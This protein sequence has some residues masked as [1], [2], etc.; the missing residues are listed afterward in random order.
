MAQDCSFWLLGSSEP[1]PLTVIAAA[2]DGP[3]VQETAPSR[4]PGLPIQFFNVQ[5]GVFGPTLNPA[6]L[7][8]FRRDLISALRK[9]SVSNFEAY[10]ASIRQPRSTETIEDY[11]VIKVQDCITL[12]S[13]T[14]PSAGPRLSVLR[15][16]TDAVVAS[17]DLRAA[18]EACDIPGLVFWQPMLV[19]DGGSDDDD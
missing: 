16:A 9:L 6:N 11:C 15:E 12:S 10:P 17:D 4:I 14:A 1:G 18:L 5:Q 3:W 7:T 19:M 13:V 2:S 8:L